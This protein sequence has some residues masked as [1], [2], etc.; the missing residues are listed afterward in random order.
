MTSF[1]EALKLYFKRAFDFQGRSTRAEFWWARLALVIG[2]FGAVALISA[3]GTVAVY[4]MIVTLI[5]IIIPDISLSVRRLHD[6]DKS[7]W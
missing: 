5:I 4:A 6:A 1:P 7:G 2:Y 3:L